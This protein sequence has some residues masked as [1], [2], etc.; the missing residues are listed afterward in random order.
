MPPY[1][2]SS[3][4]SKNRNYVTVQWSKEHFNKVR[5]MY[6]LHSSWIINMSTPLSPRKYFDPNGSAGA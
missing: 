6:L 3:S 2:P 4:L 5:E 1:T